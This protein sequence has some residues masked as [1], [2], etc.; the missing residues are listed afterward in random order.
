MET[1][2]PTRN[3]IDPGSDA[4]TDDIEN[5]ERRKTALSKC[6]NN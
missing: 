3:R 6:N 4:G 2:G 5:R 1:V